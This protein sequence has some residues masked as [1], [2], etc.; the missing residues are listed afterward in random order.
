MIKI[1]DFEIF[2]GMYIY[3]IL[4]SD[5]PGE[6]VNGIENRLDHCSITVSPPLNPDHEAIDVPDDLLRQLAVLGKVSLLN[7][8]ALF[9]EKWEEWKNRENIAL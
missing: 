1:Y 6:P 7:F 3:F 8:R 4:N 5:F 2:L 9:T